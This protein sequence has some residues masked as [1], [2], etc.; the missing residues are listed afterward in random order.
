[1]PQHQD[2]MTEPAASR[3]SPDPR[4]MADEIGEYECYCGLGPACPV[5]LLMTP[6]ERTACTRDKRRTA[7]SYYRNGLDV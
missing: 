4:A 1:M 2:A 7:Q 3:G 6:D 5:F